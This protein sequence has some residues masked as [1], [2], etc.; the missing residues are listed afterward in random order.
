[1][2]EELQ[3]ERDLSRTPL[4]QV[5]FTFQNHMPSVINFEGLRM[6]SLPLANPTAKFDLSLD[7]AE[8]EAG[9]SASFEYSTDLFEAATIERLAAHFQNLLTG[10]ITNPDERL[11]RLPL[12]TESERELVLTQWSGET[13]DYARDRCMHELFAEQVARTPEAVAV[14]DEDQQ[15]TYRELDHKANQLAHYLQR[16]GVGPDALVG[17][18][19]ERSIEMVVGLLGI[20][21]AGGAY[22]ALDPQYPR[23]RLAFML[24]DSDVDLILTQQ[25][26][27][28]AVPQHNMQVVLLDADWQ[29]ITTH[30]DSIHTPNEPMTEH[31]AHIIY[32][33]GSTG[34][35]KGVMIEHRSLTNYLQ[36]VGK[37][38]A[39][40]PGDRMLQFFSLSVDG[41][42]ED[43][44]S[45]LT[46]GATVVLRT[47]EMMATPFTFLQECARHRITVLDLPVAYWHELTANLS[48]EDWAQLE[49]LRLIVIGGEEPLPERF[50]QWH[51][52]VDRRVRLINTYG[53]TEATVIAT[54]YELSRGNAAA[55]ADADRRIPIG[56][57]LEN[58]RTYVLDKQLQPVP[59]GVLGELYLGG[60]ALARGY[61]NDP[62]LT[63][64]RFV[65]DPFSNQNGTRLYHTG[66]LVRYLPDGNIEFRGRNDHQVKVR[67]FRVEL[68]EVESAIVEHPLVHDA[69]VMARDDVGGKRLVAYVVPATSGELTAGELRNFLRQG[70]PQ[71]MLPAHFILLDAL[72]LLPNGKLD[73]RAL[74]EPDH[75]RPELAAEYVAPR[76]ETEQRVAAIWKEV[77]GIESVG[78]HDNFF[79]LGGHSL[80]A[81]QIVSRLRSA[82]Q[83][84]LPLRRLFETPTVEGL[85][86][87]VA[88]D[89]E[90]RNGTSF[91]VIERTS[92]GAEEV[93]LENLD[94]LS[95]DEVEL[96][97]QG[98]LG[99]PRGII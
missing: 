28:D 76:D 34:R 18:M 7:L 49:D 1:L 61:F 79:D 63:A 14:V 36:A 50:A 58:V 39:L 68:G 25:A 64:E 24:D 90:G 69:V 55:A 77:L 8:T 96:L 81:T 42:A 51:R 20:L 6:S 82:F 67:G 74:P 48:A 11:S 40:Q 9:L 13:W 80:L 84:E 17:I 87:A 2:V 89:A 29:A 19:V 95:D 65:P 92:R 38:F 78:V 52:A 46:R 70:L 66:D 22:V 33:S 21:K 37:R 57:A 27:L 15:L 97:L 23:D 56:R 91:G 62:G 47:T 86:L 88:S 93:L 44:Y 99:D 26:L 5:M 72:P 3:P 31:L 94:Q 73:R 83:A 60:D 12:L 16:Q 98:T 10:I 85:A 43:L 71:F 35:P 41:I 75:S 54:M 32:T 53:P 30:Q 4:F 45:C 59:T